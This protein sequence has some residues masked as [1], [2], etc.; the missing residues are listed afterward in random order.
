MLRKTWVVLGAVA[1]I[2]IT[3]I[4]AFAIEDVQKR[5]VEGGIEPSNGD[6]CR[7]FGDPAEYSAGETP[8]SVAV[9]DFDDDGVQDLAVT[10]RYSYDV[11]ILM[12]L[13][14][15][16][17]SGET[18]FDLWN[19]AATQSIAVGD[20]D[21]DGMADLVT[22]NQYSGD[23]QLLRGDGHG[24]FDVY[25]RYEVGYPYSI[26]VG[27]F[28]NDGVQDLAVGGFGSPSQISVLFGLG[29]GFFGAE[30]GFD[31]EGQPMSIA[32]G[33]FDSDGVQDLAVAAWRSVAVLMGLGDGTFSE[34][35][36]YDPGQPGDAE[37]SLAIGDFNGD[38]VQDL[39][40]IQD[41]DYVFVLFGLG[42]GSFGEEQGF[43]VGERPRSVAVGDFNGDG[44]QDLAVTNAFNDTVSVL[45]NQCATLAV[46]IDI[47]PHSHPHSINPRSRGVIPVAILGS[48]TLD[49]A[50]V[51]EV[52]LR[53]G[54]GAAPIAHRHGHLEDVNCDG[55][56]DLMLHFRTH[57]TGIACGDESVTLTGE[58]LDG[59]PFAGTDSIQTVGCRE[60]KQP[61][62][63][64][65][66]HDTPDA[67]RRGGPVNIERE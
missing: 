62:I 61:A 56:M 13:G 2:T 8:I 17:F 46:D 42:D 28:D 48:D 49:V 65:K 20:F 35:L 30:Q 1:L 52:T 54:P 50:D 3:H 26:A 15:G 27:D 64:M 38:M 12:G 34:A 41:S 29:N 37:R 22:A 23:V 19:A 67:M 7:L 33:D 6:P 51:D 11:S 47:K 58:T 5:V 24:W 9:G 16:R 25:T 53:F 21:R 57:D 44:A 66:D 36:Y 59:Q 43:R 63:W 55:I 39:A 60:V 18:R 10:N 45:I 31:I 4:A 40:V 32:I 14:D